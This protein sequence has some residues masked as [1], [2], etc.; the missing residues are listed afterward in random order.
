MLRRAAESVSRGKARRLGPEA[1]GRKCACSTLLSRNARASASIVVREGLR[2]S[3]CSRRMYQSRRVPASLATSS[4]G[5][6]GARRL[7]PSGR[8]TDFGLSL[9]RRERR[10]L[11]NSLRLG[12]GTVI[13]PNAGT[14]NP[15]IVLVLP[16]SAICDYKEIAEASTGLPWLPSR[17][18]YSGTTSLI[19]SSETTSGEP[20]V[21]WFVHSYV[22]QDQRPRSRVLGGSL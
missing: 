10:K 8:P 22:A 4:R 6:P 2:G 21:A 18:S 9:A 19:H 20:H 11:P 5:R 3:A 14:H 7:R 17:T 12:S 16:R 13:F 1:R 15:R